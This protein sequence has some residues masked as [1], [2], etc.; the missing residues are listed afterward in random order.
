MF[1]KRT[2]KQKVNVS[3]VDTASE[4]LALSLAEKAC[5]DIPYMTNLTGK[6]EATLVEELHG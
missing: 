4:P 1:T 6:D 3:R 5:I 2:I